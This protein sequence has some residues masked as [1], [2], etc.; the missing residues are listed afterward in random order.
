VTAEDAAARRTVVGVGIATSALQDSAGDPALRRAV[1][2]ELIEALSVHGTLVFTSQ[3]HL[4]LFV[5]AVRA[6]PASLAKA[7]ETVLSSRRVQV[8]IRDPESLAALSEV[9]DPAAFDQQLAPDVQLVLLDPDHA[10]LLG[11]AE[12]E[13][14]ARTPGG[15]VEIGRITTAGRTTTLLA[16]R[17]VLDA[18]L[19]EGVNREQEWQERF[20]PLCEAASPIVIYDKFVGQQVMRRYVYDAQSGDGLTWFLNRLSMTPGRRVRVITA[21]TDDIDR[22]RRFDEETAALAFTRLMQPLRERRLRLDL[23]L[24]PDRVRGATVRSVRFGHDRHIRFGNRTALALG[25][26]MQVFAT[27]TFRETTT[28]ARLPI[29]DAKAREEQAIRGALRPPEGGWLLGH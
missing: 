28:V 4:D 9:L 23:V 1:H 19:R 5:A 27:G 8:Q 12:D 14:S 24:V 3:A 26:G 10:E 13:Y 7:W 22:G 17:T 15:L 16:A 25:A 2:E 6:L 11:V 29:A 18:P 20:G 21:V